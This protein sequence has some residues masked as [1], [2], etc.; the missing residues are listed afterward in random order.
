MSRRTF[1]RAVAA[2][3]IVAALG[4]PAAGQA[5]NPWRGES[6]LPTAPA[7]RLVASKPT[8]MLSISL[9]FSSV[10]GLMGTLEVR[11]L[12]PPT[13]ATVK[14]PI[15]IVIEGITRTLPSEL[16][17]RPLPTPRHFEHYPQYFPPNPTFPLPRELATMTDPDGA[18]RGGATG[19]VRASYLPLSGSIP[20][21]AYMPPPAPLPVQYIP[22][23][24]K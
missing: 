3:L 17:V 23:A 20:V 5:P 11:D 18:A 7:P 1:P 2:G 12:R 14:A 24:A 4:G 6:A 9:G 19:V 10:G 8:R 16:I 22:P 15:D 13:P 21:P